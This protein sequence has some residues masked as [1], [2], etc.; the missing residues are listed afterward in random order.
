MVLLETLRRM[1]GDYGWTSFA[2][3]LA[4]ITVGNGTLTGFYT[5]IGKT[6]H[7]RV[8]LLFGS[9]TAVTGGVTLTLPTTAKDTTFGQPIGIV[10]LF[11]TGTATYQGQIVIT[12]SVTVIKTDGTYASNV[13]LSSTVPHTW[14]TGDEIVIEGTYETS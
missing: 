1:I 8:K 7:I 3:S 13:A 6:V 2:P 5:K 9:T 12:G 11:D 10:R 14:A 4:G